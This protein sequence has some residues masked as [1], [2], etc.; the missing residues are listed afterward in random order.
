MTT[1]TMQMLAVGVIGVLLYGA[2][3]GVM[4]WRRRR[5][6]RWPYRSS[7]RRPEPWSAGRQSD[8]DTPPSGG[9][10]G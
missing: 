7:P 8:D 3:R 9:V 4:E 2:I 6:D 1:V 5:R 10:G